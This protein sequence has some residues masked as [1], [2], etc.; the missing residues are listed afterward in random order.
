MTPLFNDLQW[1]RVKDLV[2]FSLVV[3]LI[4][5][6]IK[7]LPDHILSLPAVNAITNS[8][9]RQQNNL[10]VPRTNTDAGARALSVLGP[11]LWSSLPGEIKDSNYVTA[12][13]MKLKKKFLTSV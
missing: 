9:T 2:T 8:T 6:K 7:V 11:K 10:Y 4:K 3:T 1:P 5:H 13:K 12:L